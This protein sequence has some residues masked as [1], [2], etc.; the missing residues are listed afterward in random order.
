MDVYKAYGVDKIFEPGSMGI[1]I[2]WFEMRDK[3]FVDAAIDLLQRPRTVPRLI[4][5]LTVWNHGPHGRSTYADRSEIYSG[6][7]REIF[8][9]PYDISQVGNEQLKDYINR[10]NNSI[11]AYR[12]LEDYIEMSP[13]PTVIV[14]YGD[15]HPGFP[16]DFS[17]HSRH[18]FG[19]EVSYVTFYRI[20]RNFETHTNSRK[21]GEYI[22]VDQLFRDALVFGGIRL[23]PELRARDAVL[24]QCQNKVSNCNDEQRR[25]LRS[26]ILK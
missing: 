23:S 11:T 7:R 9:G 12:R 22:G 8:S 10:L 14:Y 16:R 3:F 20:A 25:T 19:N 4:M 6:P 24:D 13:V 1:P 21:N 15:H 5:L 2:Q 17:E 18:R 26:I